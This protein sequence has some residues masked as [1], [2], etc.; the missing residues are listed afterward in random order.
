MAPPRLHFAFLTERPRSLM[1][2]I[3]LQNEVDDCPYTGK[4]RHTHRPYHDEPAKTFPP[5]WHQ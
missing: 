2:L 1:F 4:H 3:E 5:A